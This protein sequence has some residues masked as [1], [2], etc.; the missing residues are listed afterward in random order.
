MAKTSPSNARDTGPIPD[1]LTKIPHASWPKNQ[2]SV[3]TNSVK[4]LKMLHIT[5]KKKGK[6][7]NYQKRSNGDNS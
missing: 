1:Q 4:T 5:K 2:N 3:V 7:K 6:K